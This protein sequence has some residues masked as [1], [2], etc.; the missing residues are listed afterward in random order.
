MTDSQRISVIRWVWFWICS[1]LVA[2][3]C[4]FSF[5]V[6]VVMI[7]V[8]QIHFYG[9]QMPW[10]TEKVLFAGPL[11]PESD[12][13]CIIVILTTFVGLAVFL[14]GQAKDAYLSNAPAA[15]ALITIAYIMLLNFCFLLPFIPV[16]THL[17]SD[18]NYA[19]TPHAHLPDPDIPP[20]LWLIG[21]FVYLIIVVVGIVALKRKEKRIEQIGK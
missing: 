19:S 21:S 2:V 18:P 7:Q 14:R 11:Y 17:S 15:V 16:I 1:L 8:L 10:I 13:A 4:L 6:R 9:A 20:D 3:L 5:L 12:F